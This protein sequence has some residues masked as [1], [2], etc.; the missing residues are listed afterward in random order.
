MTKAAKRRVSLRDIQ[1]RRQYLEL[2]QLMDSQFSHH[3]GPALSD[4]LAYLRYWAEIHKAD[5][6]DAIQFSENYWK[7]GI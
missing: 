1:S 5:W 2:E 7:G 6:D 3:P 4:V